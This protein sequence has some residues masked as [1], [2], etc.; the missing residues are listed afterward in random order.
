MEWGGGCI[1]RGVGTDLNLRSDYGHNDSRLAAEVLCAK[2]HAL[3]VI[4]RRGGHNPLVQF[5]LREKQGRL[6]KY[7]KK[8][9]FI[10]K[11]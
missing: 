2:C 1:G 8:C 11:Y 3:S 5:R 6:S 7:P 10:I 9:L 4:S